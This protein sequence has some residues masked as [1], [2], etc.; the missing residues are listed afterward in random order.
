MKNTTTLLDHIL[1]NSSNK[2]SQYGT[3]DVGISDHL[4][5]NCTMKIIHTK[6]HDHKHIQIRSL[7]NYTK[8][9]Y[10]QTLKEINFPDYTNFNSTDVAY[11][12][13][14]AKLTDVIDKVTPIKEVR[15]KA[16]PKNG[17][18]TKSIM[19]SKTETNVSQF[20]KDQD[21][22]KIN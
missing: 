21:L 7:K 19:L 12:D 18:M 1:T 6:F 11:D 15:I 10:I 9:K 8:E 13:F 3:V 17:L 22:M 14:I 16:I 20:L 4:L 5:T 2:T